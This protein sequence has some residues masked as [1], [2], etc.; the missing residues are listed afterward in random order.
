ML[1]KKTSLAIK[2]IIII[3]ISVSSIFI[4][5]FV[6]NYYSL[7]KIYRDSARNDAR[8]LSRIVSAQ[9]SATLG[10]V[11][12]VTATIA[13]IVEKH[14]YNEA[15]LIS[16]LENAVTYNPEIHGMTIAYEPYAFDPKVAAFAPYVY[17]EQGQI[18]VSQ[19]PQNYL[20]WRWYLTPKS[21]KGA[22]WGDPYVN[23][24]TNNISSTYAVPFYGDETGKKQFQGVVSANISLEWL[25]KIVA[26]TAIGQT[27][28]AFMLYKDGYFVTAPKTE[29]VA[30]Y[31]IFFLSTLLINPNLATLGR[32]M[33]RVKKD[34]SR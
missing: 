24:F 2:L 14:H 20:N 18:E 11:Q 19:A 15:E 9:V 22:V 1:L 8:N 16:F 30:D 33:I 26:S 34:S 10:G 32:D 4:S 12:K 3:V 29:F 7:K 31:S 27:G 6:F 17:R 5:A 13:T 25:E 28:Y 23:T 21:G